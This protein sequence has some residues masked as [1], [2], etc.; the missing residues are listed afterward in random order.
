MA[1]SACLDDGTCRCVASD[2]LDLLG[3]KYAMDVLC[4]I[5]NHET[6]RFSTL[7]DH[8]PEASTS[9]LSTRLDELEAA[10]IVDREQFD[11]VPPRV[12]YSLSDDGTALAERLRPLFEWV[13]EWDGADA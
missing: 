8:L 6:V 11:E 1:E 4:V 13:A 10:C 3:T 12:E 2:V 5:G 7:E 9:T